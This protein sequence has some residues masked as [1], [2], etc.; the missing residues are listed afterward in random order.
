MTP[1]DLSF[2]KDQVDARLCT[3]TL[4]ESEIAQFRKVRV[5]QPNRA[6]M[7]IP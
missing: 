7:C 4:T 2:R 5:A 1:Y 3:K 6:C